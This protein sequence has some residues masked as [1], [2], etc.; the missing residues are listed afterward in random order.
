M[1]QTKGVGMRK[2]RQALY[3]GGKFSLHTG[4]LLET[5]LT[6]VLFLSLNKPCTIILH[7]IKRE[8]TPLTGAGRQKGYTLCVTVNEK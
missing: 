3:K 5:T 8:K 1:P 4:E 6:F 2:R 7:T